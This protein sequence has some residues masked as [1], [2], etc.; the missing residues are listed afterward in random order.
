MKPHAAGIDAFSSGELRKSFSSGSL[1]KT[2]E[3]SGG[4]SGYRSE[5]R[6]PPIGDGK[7]QFK[8]VLIPAKVVKTTIYYKAT[9]RG[10]NDLGEEIT[11][12]ETKAMSQNKYISVKEAFNSIPFTFKVVYTYGSKELLGKGETITVTNV[13]IR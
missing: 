2:R 6:R 11:T 4:G 7:Y 12:V 3:L 1:N 8:G 10:V 9:I 5:S 13:N